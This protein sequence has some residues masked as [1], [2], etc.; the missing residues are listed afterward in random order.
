MVWMQLVK[1]K[2]DSVKESCYW[3]ATPTIDPSVARAM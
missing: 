1:A 2:V 3:I